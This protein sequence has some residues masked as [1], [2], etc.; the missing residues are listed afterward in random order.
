MTTK[1]FTADQFTPT[2]FST[3]ADKAKFA[4]HFA[5][6]VLSGFRRTMFPRWFYTRLS[7]TFGHIAHYNQQ[8]FY[9]VFF[10]TTRGRV[11]FLRLTIGHHSHGQA[12]YTYCDVE[13]AIIAWLDD[14]PIIAKYIRLMEDE[15]TAAD[16]ATYDRLGAR[17]G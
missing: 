14:S 5:R 2:E 6:F 3:A 13:Q 16:R 12:N 8:G 17:F 15:E 10:E 1:L 11:R 4:N 9:G 7:M